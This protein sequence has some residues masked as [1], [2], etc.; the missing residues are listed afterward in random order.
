MSLSSPVWPHGPQVLII[1]P[2]ATGSD[3]T[4]VPQRLSMSMKQTCLHP[5]AA[6]IQEPYV[7]SK[8]RLIPDYNHVGMLPKIPI[9]R[10]DYGTLE[11]AKTKTSRGSARKRPQ[12]RTEGALEGCMMYRIGTNSLAVHSP[13]RQFSGR[14]MHTVLLHRTAE[15]S[16]PRPRNLEAPRRSEAADGRGFFVSPLASFSFCFGALRDVVTWPH[17][18]GPLTLLRIGATY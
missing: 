2:Q 8:W 13:W 3:M 15:T 11:M 4:S 17:V 7:P 9:R 6:Q 16:K 18:A 14:Y 10:P 1:R 5:R 12:A